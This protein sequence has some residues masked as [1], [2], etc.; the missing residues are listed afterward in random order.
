[1]HRPALNGALCKDEKGRQQRPP[2]AFAL[3]QP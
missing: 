2:T 1:M 3:Q